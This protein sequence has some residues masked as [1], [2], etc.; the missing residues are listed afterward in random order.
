M[1]NPE[2]LT[3]IDD[4]RFEKRMPSRV[5][6]VRELLRR[7]LAVEGFAIAER[8]E[9]SSNFGVLTSGS[10]SRNKRRGGRSGNPSVR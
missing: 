1:L 5:A 6:A 4:W 10:E 3:A 7:G 2:E 8:G 9:R